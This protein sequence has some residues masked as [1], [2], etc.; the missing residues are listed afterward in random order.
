VVRVEEVAVLLE[1]GLVRMF[2]V[3]GVV[4]GALRCGVCGGYVGARGTWCLVRNVV[5]GLDGYG[6]LPGC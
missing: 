3:P 6:L 4:G 2:L 5:R 1:D